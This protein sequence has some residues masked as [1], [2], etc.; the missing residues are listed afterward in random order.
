[1]VSLFDG[2]SSLG[3][4]ASELLADPTAE[5]PMLRIEPWRER[6]RLGDLVELAED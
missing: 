4:D 2:P 1:M 5:P 3:D 6:V